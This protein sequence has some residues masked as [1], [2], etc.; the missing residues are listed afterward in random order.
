MGFVAQVSG[1]VVGEPAGE[2]R[3]LLVLSLAIDLLPVSLN[4]QY[5]RGPGKS[6]LHLTDE[7]RSI[8]D[9]F[10]IEANLQHF[11]ARKDR[12]YEVEV[13]FTF[14]EWSMDSDNYLK[15]LMDALFGTRGDHRIVRHHVKKRVMPGT[16]STVVSV[17][18]C[19]TPWWAL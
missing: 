5:Q 19:K 15:P 10:T 11:R 14:P 1:C 13:T 12:Y 9:A 18:E 4:H 16:S 6:K 3:R 17:Y 2:H 7:A 8:R